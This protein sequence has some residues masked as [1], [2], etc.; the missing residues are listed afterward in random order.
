[1][2]AVVQRVS[3]ARVEVHGEVVG[4]IDRGLVVYL[5]IANGDA[6]GDLEYLVHKVAGLRIFEDERGRMARAVDEESR[7]V[8]VVSQFTLLGDVRR[9]RRPSFSDAAPP[10]R[11]EALCEGF[12]GRLRALGLTV[13]T[14]RFQAKMAVHVEVDGPVTILLDSRK[15]F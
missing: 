11:A 10:E 4:A 12:V 15:G 3:A 7:Q 13:A 5:G 8:L 1:M 2:R 14:G 9:G 6:E